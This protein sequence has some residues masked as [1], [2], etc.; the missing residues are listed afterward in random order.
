MYESLTNKETGITIGCMMFKGKPVLYIQRELT[1][2]IFATFQTS[3][4][5]EEFIEVLKEFDKGGGNDCDL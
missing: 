1:R 3:Q 4:K 2:R 5:A